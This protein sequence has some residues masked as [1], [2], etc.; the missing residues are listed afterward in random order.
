[1]ATENSR[2]RSIHWT[3]TATH[4]RIINYKGI[5]DADTRHETVKHSQNEWVS[6]DVHPNSV[7]RVWSLFK[8]SVVGTSF[9]R[10]IWTLIWTNWS[11]VL[12][13]AI[14]GFCSVIHY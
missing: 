3:H 1:M 2:S 4:S 6:G 10:S 13:I 8:R 9:L 5:E 14:I 7:E 12:T 11:I